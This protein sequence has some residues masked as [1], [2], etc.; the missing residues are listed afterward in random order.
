MINLIRSAITLKE[1]RLKSNL[2]H[3]EMMVAGTL[4]ISVVAKINLPCEGGSS[5][6]LSN[7]LNA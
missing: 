1:I 2:W 4:W 3:L 5:K 6:V 7:A